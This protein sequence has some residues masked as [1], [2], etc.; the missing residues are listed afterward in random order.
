MKKNIEKLFREIFFDLSSK[1]ETKFR[2]PII[3]FS[4]CDNL[5][6]FKLK[7]LIKNHH[8]PNELLKNGKTVIC[9]FLPFDKVFFFKK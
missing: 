2:E 9:Y 3:K 8:H 6:Y 5:L 7:K 4:S 1:I